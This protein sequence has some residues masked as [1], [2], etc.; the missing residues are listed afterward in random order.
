MGTLVGAGAFTAVIAA[1]PLGSGL[2]DRT[3]HG[4]NLKT[5]HGRQNIQ[6]RARVCMARQHGTQHLG[7]VGN[8]C[9]AQAGAGPGAFGDIQT[10]QA[11]QQQRSR[12]GITNAH[13]TQQQRIAGQTLHQRNAVAQGLRTLRRVHGGMLRR[14]SSS[15][16]RPI[17]FAH[18]QA[19]T[20]CARS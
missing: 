7:F 12:R 16:M 17:G 15:Q 20:L 13:F 11:R 19:C 6:R 3:D 4:G 2:H 5:T 14:I 10:G 8:G 9:V 18:Q 1:A